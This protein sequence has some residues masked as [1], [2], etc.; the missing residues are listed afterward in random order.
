MDR[1]RRTDRK[2]CGDAGAGKA[3]TGEAL[4]PPLAGVGLLGCCGRVGR[5]RVADGDEH[6][7]T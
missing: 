7:Q 3:P 6:Q 2:A 1:R 5:L 4:R